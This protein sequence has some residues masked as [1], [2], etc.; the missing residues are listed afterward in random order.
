MKIVR[1]D[2]EILRS[3]VDH[4]LGIGGIGRTDILR[5]VAGKP[6]STSRAAVVSTSQLDK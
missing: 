2:G 6:A 1:Q 5:C 3:G 4:N